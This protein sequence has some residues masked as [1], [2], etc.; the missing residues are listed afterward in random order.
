ME[1]IREIENPGDAV[2]REVDIVPK[3]ACGSRNYHNPQNQRAI[4]PAK[5]KHRL[6]IVNLGVPAGGVD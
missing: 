1:R 4:E 6:D 3:A 5:Y 2:D